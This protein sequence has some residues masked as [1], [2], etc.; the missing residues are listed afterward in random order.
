ML[1]RH[2]SGQAT[3]VRKDLWRNLRLMKRL[4]FI[5]VANAS[6]AGEPTIFLFRQ[7]LSGKICG[8]IYV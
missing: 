1:K 6:C 7:R 8:G 2:L 3:P 5:D 4:S